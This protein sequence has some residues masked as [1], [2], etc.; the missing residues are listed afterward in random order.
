MLLALSGAAVGLAGC[1]STS[2]KTY[3]QLDRDH[4]SFHTDTCQEAIRYTE[5][6]DDLK[7]LRSIASPVVVW[8]PGGVLF[9]AVMAANVGLDTVDRVDASKLEVQCGGQGKTAGQIAEGVA[10]DAALGLATSA[11]GSALTGGSFIPA[12]LTPGK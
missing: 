3:A 4:P 9:P 2:A 7:I 12:G 11:A 6:H 1:A 5:V 10:T 8:L